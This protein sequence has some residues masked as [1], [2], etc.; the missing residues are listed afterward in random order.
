MILVVKLSEKQITLA[1]NTIGNSVVIFKWLVSN[2]WNI[3]IVNCIRCTP[4][5]HTRG[6]QYEAAP[7]RK[8]YKLTLL[9]DCR[10]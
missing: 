9:E 4:V 2:Q 5:I 6:A 8:Y 10:I 3:L 1:E 7:K